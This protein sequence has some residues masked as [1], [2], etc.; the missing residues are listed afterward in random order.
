MFKCTWL[1]FKTGLLFK[2]DILLSHGSL[3]NAFASFFLFKPNLALED[4]GNHEQVRLYKP[5]T[6]AIITSSSFP[7]RYGKKQ[8]FYEGY[9]ELAYLHPDVFTA[10][11][12]V[13]KELG[14]GEHEKYFILRFV[15]WNA[16]HD[17]GQGGLPLQDKKDLIA[18]LKR[19]GKVFISSEKALEA[20]FEPYR[21]SLPPWRMHDAMACC[22]LFVGEG[23]TMAS[24][25]A[26]LGT[27]AV[28][29]NS[30]Q[31]GYILEEQDYGL[32][33][34][35]VNGHGVLEKVKELLEDT[36]LDE[37]IKHAHAKLI[38]EKINVSDFLVWFIENYPQSF[39]MMKKDTAPP[40]RY[41][42]ER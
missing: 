19:Y 6:K 34:S 36:E 7:M 14:V 20:E 10:D 32:A 42:T 3:V 28:Y 13:L 40:V 9:H 37:K 2:P 31:R 4:T 38:S 18:L 16:S 15:S 30:L 22:T 21:F 27:P 24:E 8:I 1:V 23:A 26:V 25:C 29:V 41:I 5:F 33:F 11:K 39:S 12:T 17:V 35:F